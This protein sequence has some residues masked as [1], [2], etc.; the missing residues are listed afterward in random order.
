MTSFLDVHAISAFYGDAQALRDVSLQV[1]EGEI[2][3]LIGAKGGN[4]LSG[5]LS[6]ADTTAG[7]KDMT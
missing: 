2:V 4:G 6:G 7:D 5:G 1:N 3:G